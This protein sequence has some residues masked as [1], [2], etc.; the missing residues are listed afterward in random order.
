LAA[1]QGRAE[2]NLDEA[3]AQHDVVHARGQG[4][5][6]VL[7]HLRLERLARDG[8]VRNAE[9]DRAADALGKR[10][11]D[12]GKAANRGPDDDGTAG[13]LAKTG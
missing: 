6:Q 12:S 7:G 11:E 9:A 1:R 8:E 10:I 3:R 13:T 4:L 5:F 2:A